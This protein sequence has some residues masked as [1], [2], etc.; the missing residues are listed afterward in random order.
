MV[1]EKENMEKKQTVKMKLLPP[2][3]VEE[4]DQRDKGKAE[5]KKREVCSDFFFLLDKVMP[6]VDFL[7]GCTECV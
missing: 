1:R 5:E 6:R 2:S 4:R 3:P 7:C